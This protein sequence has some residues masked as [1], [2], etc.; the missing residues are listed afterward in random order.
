MKD[1][2]ISYNKADRKWAEWIAWKL[3]EANYDVVIQ[4]WDFRPGENFVLR[5][6]DALNNT[7]K[8]ILVLSDDYLSSSFTA[9]EWS[10]V[11]ATD[12][13]AKERKLVPVRVRECKPDGLLGTLIYVDLSILSEPDAEAALLGAFAPRAKPSVAPTFPGK[14]KGKRIRP[15]EFPGNPQLGNSVSTVQSRVPEIESVA[16]KVPVP[17]FERIKLNDDLNAIVPGQFNML[18]FALNPPPGLVPPMPAPQAE[19][20]TALLAWATSPSGVGLKTLEEVLRL[21]TNPR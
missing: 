6:Q 7:Q 4:A 15:S 20:S 11:F 2:F 17:I 9:A 14:D 19:R 8:M 5:M 10:A 13:A 1:F 12:P 21:I 18:L 3:E 16:P